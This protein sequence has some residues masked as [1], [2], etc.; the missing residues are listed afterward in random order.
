MLPLRNS[1]DNKIKETYKANAHLVL[2]ALVLQERILVR[3]G[4]VSCQHCQLGT[5]YIKQPFKAFGHKKTM[6]T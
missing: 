3:K 4:G 1:R 5:N 2:C 6:K